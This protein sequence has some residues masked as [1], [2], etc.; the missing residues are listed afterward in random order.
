MEFRTSWYGFFTNCLGSDFVAS[1]LTKSKF[2]HIMNCL[3]FDIDFLQDSFNES[4]QGIYQPTCILSADETMTPSKSRNNPHHMFIPGKPH[5]NGT[6]FTSVADENHL[7]LGYKIRRRD[8][9]DWQALLHRYTEEIRYDRSQC[10][11]PENNLPLL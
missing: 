8:K 5:P 11:K 1:V 9:E 6:L 2:D 3:D 10:A 7:I 4:L